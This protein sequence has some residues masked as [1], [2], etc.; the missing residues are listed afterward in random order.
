MRKLAVLLLLAVVVVG[1]SSSE[2]KKEEGAKPAAT[3]AAQPKAPELQTGRTA[4]YEMYRNAAHTW[5]PDAKPYRL[6]SS[7]SK[8][9][10]G[11]DGK[12]IV[13]HAWFASPS[14]KTVKPYTWS[15]GSG[16][17]LPEKGISFGP[18][19]TFNPSNTSTQPFD[20]NFLKT[21]SD[22]A[23]KAAQEKGGETLEKKS[24]GTPIVYTLDWSPKTNELIWHVS[25]GES[26]QDYK[27][28]IAVDASTGGFLR[29]EK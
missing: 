14:K 4:F 28:K 9:A 13:W 12:A 26:P 5:A 21:D 10:P 29:K 11:T 2:P 8:S 24:P 23:Y 6:Q 19:D 25:Y 16:D 1:C 15:G 22:Q 27:L 20:V 18:E 17:D 7:A 3:Q